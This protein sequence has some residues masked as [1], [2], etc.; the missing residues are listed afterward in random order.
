MKFS[1]K[2]LVWTMIVMALG[3]GFSGVYFVNYVFQTALEREAVSCVLPLRQLPL[4]C[5]PNMMCCRIPQWDR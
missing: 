1:F 2:L 3:F 4:M 5:L